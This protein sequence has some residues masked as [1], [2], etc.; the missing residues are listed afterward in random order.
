MKKTITIFCLTAGALTVSAQPGVKTT[1]T[2]LKP[3]VKTVPKVAPVLKNYNDSISYVLGEMSA[4]SI[5]PQ[6]F[7]D[8]QINTTAFSRAITDIINKKQTLITDIAANTMLNQYVM[9]LQESKAKE[10]IDSGRVFLAENAKR[11]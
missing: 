4:F 5:I 7:G 6:G 10:R 1:K 8:V 2:P 11:K 3:K 9:K